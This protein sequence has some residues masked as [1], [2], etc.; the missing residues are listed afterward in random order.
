V[1]TLTL[2]DA[3]SWLDDDAATSPTRAALAIAWSLAQPH[4]HGEVG[5]VDRPCVVGRETSPEH[6]VFAQQRP[7]HHEPAAPLVGRALS[8]RQ[9][10]LHPSGTGIQ[11][12][13]TGRCPTFVNGA[14]VTQAHLTA[15]DTV[16]VANQL[17]FVVTE[18]P[19]VLS[20]LRHRQIAFEFGEP[21]RYG[22]VGESPTT[23]HMRDRLAFAAR[24][25]VH[26]LLLGPSGAG[27]ELAA[28]TVHGLSTRAHKPLVSRSAATLPEGLID[29]ELFG[30]VRN[31]PNPGMPGRPGLVGE[32]HESTLFLD[33]IGELPEALQAHLLRVLDGDGE[34]Q[35]LGETTPRRS[36]FRLVAATNRSADALKHDLSAR[37][38]VRVELPGLGERSEDVPLLAWALLRAA[39]VEDQE[40]GASFFENWDGATG[41]PRIAPDLISALL[42]HR[43]THHVRELKALLWQSL[44]ESGGAFLALTPGV[45]ARLD[46]AA[47]VTE[48]GSLGKAQIEAALAHA[49]GNQAAA[50]RALGL[51]NRDVLYRLIKKHGIVVQ[52][53]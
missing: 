43:Y 2:E 5:L 21:D 30:N 3:G 52:K 49:G 51:R 8:R 20:P 37:L 24:R 22:I 33:E 32:A 23:W 53:S 29:A 15:G 19:G 1:R 27:K 45:T 14:Q 25:S 11:L 13:V 42:R 50:T 35:R 48:P 9:L 46:T 10:Q 31:Y 18:R 36:D 39:A 7:G 34:Y 28:R 16:H 38:V 26:V 41:Q 17:V 44:A 47:V 12:E 4:R 6:L 40:I